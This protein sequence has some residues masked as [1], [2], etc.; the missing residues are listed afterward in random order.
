MHKLFPHV[1][2]II[3]TSSFVAVTC[4]VNWWYSHIKTLEL[5]QKFSLGRHQ[6]WTSYGIGYSCFHKSVR[7]CS[8]A[9]MLTCYRSS[10]KS[11]CTVPRLTTVPELRFSTYVQQP[12]RVV[13]IWR[14]WWS[15]TEDA[16][17]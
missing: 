10:C 9:T 14:I 2:S 4:M 11:S 8:A 17:T 1:I 12:S 16:W 13:A 15:A 5:S 3:L 7:C 6:E